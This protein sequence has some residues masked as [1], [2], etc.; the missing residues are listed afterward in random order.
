MGVF[1]VEN[2][3]SKELKVLDAVSSGVVK[4]TS[5]YGAI[6]GLAKNLLTPDFDTS[7]AGVILRPVNGT[8]QAPGSTS[9][10]ASTIDEIRERFA[11]TYPS[12]NEI[13][14]STTDNGEGYVL[15]LRWDLYLKLYNGTEVS[16]RAEDIWPRLT[17]L[18]LPVSI[19]RNSLYNPNGYTTSYRFNAFQY[20]SNTMYVTNTAIADAAVDANPTSW[21]TAS[22]TPKYTKT[23]TSKTGDNCVMV[24]AT[25]TAVRITVTFRLGQPTWNGRA[26]PLVMEKFC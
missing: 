16:V 25:K 2:G 17:N 7:V 5:W 20:K 22:V 23:V 6:G 3:V 19:Y 10:V 24:G 9:A 26:I 13:R 18:Y 15:R 14:I 1:T 12:E 8:L 4:T 21:V 11:I